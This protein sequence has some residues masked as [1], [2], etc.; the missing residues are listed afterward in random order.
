[1]IQNVFLATLVANSHAETVE[2]G[3]MSPL[4]TTEVLGFPAGQQ[5][6]LLSLLQP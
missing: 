2:A 4:R 3:H 5:T 1:M 6:P